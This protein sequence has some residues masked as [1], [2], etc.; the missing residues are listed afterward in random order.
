MKTP[1][2]LVTVALTAAILLA[3]SLLIVTTTRGEDSF[4][5]L[6]GRAAGRTVPTPPAGK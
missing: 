5:P 3:A 2:V 4:W 1:V 6:G